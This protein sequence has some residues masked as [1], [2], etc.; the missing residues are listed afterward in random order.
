MCAERLAQVVGALRRGGLLGAV[1]VAAIGSGWPSAAAG[2]LEETG[3]D[4]RAAR[5]SLLCDPGR[6]AYAALGLRRGV[7]RTFTW[8]RWANVAGL[9]AFPVQACCR[10][11]LPG[12]N[13]GDPWQQGGTFVYGPRGSPPTFALR[14]ETPGWPALDE[15]ALLDGVRAALAMAAGGSVAQE[16]GSHAAAARAAP[17]ALRA[18]TS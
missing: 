8:R 10:R 6:G 9:L 13:A 2:L 4:A 18:K 14:E 3:L 7:A 15:A 11:R 5:L 1:R 17:S 12:V 16:A